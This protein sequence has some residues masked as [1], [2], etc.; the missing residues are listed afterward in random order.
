[1]VIS[2]D[3]ALRPV[4]QWSEREADGRGDC[5]SVLTILLR[6]PACKIGCLHCDLHHHAHPQP[7]RPGDIVQQ[8]RF[9]QQ[10]HPGQR[11]IK[12]YNGGNFTD[13]DSIP[14]EDYDA[15]ASLCANYERVIIENHPRLP[16]DRMVEFSA[17]LRGKLE[18]AMGL[19]SADEAV[20]GRL[21]KG[22]RAEHFRLTAAA[23]SNAGIDVR[24]FVIAGMPG[25]SLGLIDG[26][27]SS[28]RYAIEAGARHV[29]VIPVRPTTPMLVDELKAGNCPT[30]SGR[31]LESIQ[32]ACLS[33]PRAVVTID[34]WDHTRWSQCAGCSEQR[35][36]NIESM[37]LNQSISPAAPC[38]VCDVPN[39]GS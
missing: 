39:Q 20:L 33:S 31:A 34:T 29:S 35:L 15:I 5:A 1:M 7:M 37:N 19:E 21:K 32:I 13:T 17:M 10:Q 11:W 28:V 36:K 16:I 12:L 4:G 24:A 25:E 9:A 6:S 38:N 8:I 23:L 30:V 22:M 3:A 26:A 2:L 14:L 18:V 27:V